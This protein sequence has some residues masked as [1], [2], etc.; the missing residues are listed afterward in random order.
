MRVLRIE[1]KHGDIVLPK[2]G[3]PF[4]D[5]DNTQVIQMIGEMDQIDGELLG[6]RIALALE[7]LCPDPPD[8]ED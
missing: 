2:Q 5:T 6:Q 3:K 8:D 4:V 7:A 1:L